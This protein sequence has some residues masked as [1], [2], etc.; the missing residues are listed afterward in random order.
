ME[1]YFIL[2]LIGILWFVLLVSGIY[3]VAT[4]RVHSDRSR[5]FFGIFAL[6]S[7]YALMQKIFFIFRSDTIEQ[8]YYNMLPFRE[9]CFGLVCRFMFTL[10]PVE[11]ARPN[12]LTLRRMALCISPWVACIVLYLALFGTYQTPL[13][14]FADVVTNAGKPDVALRLVLLLFMLP[15]EFVWT[16][17][18]DPMKSSA[19]R[20][21]MRNM[22]LMVSLIALAFVGNVLTRDAGWRIFHAVIYLA[23]IMYVMYVEMHVRIPVPEARGQQSVPMAESLPETDDKDTIAQRIIEA[24]NDGELWRNP[25]LMLSDLAHHV[26]SNRT[27]VTRAIKEMGYSGFK[28][29]VNHLRVEYIRHQLHNPR[30]E[31]LQ[32]LFFDA[33]FRSRASAWRNFTAIEGCSPSE[34]DEKNAVKNN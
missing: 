29:Y 2:M 1:H 7:S 20:V 19:G 15:Y 8:Y 12:W 14:T 16:I 24:M 13:H 25:D 11:V 32:A 22:T 3:M 23:Y 18:Y 4:R 17:V 34:Y 33:G 30:H 28:D 5:L 9:I 21:W 6:V 27:Y 31:K 10:Y 26:G